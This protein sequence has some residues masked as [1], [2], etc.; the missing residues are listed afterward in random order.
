MTRLKAS[1]ITSLGVSLTLA[2]ATVLIGSS[3]A[4]AAQ[5]A[6]PEAPANLRVIDLQ[7]NTVTVAWDPA[8]GA[9]DY[10]VNLYGSYWYPIETVATEETTQTFHVSQGTK[11][12]VAVLARGPGGLS[13]LTDRIDFTTPV[14][15]DNPAVTTPANLRADVGATEVTVDWDPSTSEAGGVSYT[16]LLEYSYHRKWFHTNEPTMTF[17]VGPSTSYE[18]RVQASDAASRLSAWSD[19]LEFTT[20]DAPLPSTPENV[21]ATTSPGSATV[22]W[23]PSTAELGVKDYQV[24]FGGLTRLTVDTTA[25]FAVPPGGEFTV[26]VKARDNAYRW[27]ASSDPIEVTVD[28][29]EE[30]EPLTA[31]SNLRAVPD[32]QGGVIFEWD[33]AAGGLGPL[34]Y[35]LYLDGT[36]IESTQDL[37]LQSP[38]FVECTND[39]QTRA[40]FVVTARSHGVESPASNPI[41]LCFA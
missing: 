1:R 18:V 28:P 33:A 35:L 38:Y 4:P 36:E 22:E 25:T 34:T 26:T 14:D 8:A 32:Q 2:V 23:D 12:G 29:A 21:R 37:H 20:P 27:S 11:Y 10:V 19:P 5:D 24:T 7:S 3:P 17:A 39:W 6:V 15:E 31:P 41:T 30:W 9:T 16:L 40:S 13:A